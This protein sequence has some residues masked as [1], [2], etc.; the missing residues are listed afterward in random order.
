[1]SNVITA[2]NRDTHLRTK[3][4]FYQC[5]WLD[6]ERGDKEQVITPTTAHESDYKAGYYESMSNL[7]TLEGQSQNE[8][9][10]NNSD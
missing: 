2:P 3:N 6:A 10:I 5:G 9:D 7:F 1:M 4:R 8:E